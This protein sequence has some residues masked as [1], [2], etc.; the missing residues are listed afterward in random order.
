[1]SKSY[2]REEVVMP[3]ALLRRYPEII[4]WSIITAY[5][6]SISHGLYVPNKESCSIDDK[7]I[8]SIC[9][10][11]LSC[12]FGLREYGSRG[13]KEIKYREWDIVV[14]EFK[15]CIG[16]LRQGNPNILCI[17]WME[18][19]DYLKVSPEG[20]RLINARSLFVGRH[21]Y[22]SFAGYARGQLHRMT[23]LA[24]QGYMGEKRKKLVQKFGYD[25]KNASHLIRL[26]RMGIEFLEEGRLYVKRKD[27]QDLLA[28]KQ[29]KWPLAQVKEESN[30]LFRKAESAYKK[31]KLP[32]RPDEDKINAL[33]VNIL[34][35][36][37]CNKENSIA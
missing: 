36:H 37:F 28:I 2:S 34:Q 1:M 29:G 4:E 23:H 33:C 26:L 10:P 5:R 14:Y 25:V 8:M 31:S 35:N 9:I 3:A 21:V 11:P 20:A 6:G 15:K 13:T 7:D 32:L 17:L 22:H 18:P 24:F 16:L 19:D 30:K 27:A 12:Y